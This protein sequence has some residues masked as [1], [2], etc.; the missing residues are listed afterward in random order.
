MKRME[1]EPCDQVVLDRDVSE[2][3]GDVGRQR[4]AKELVNDVG[5]PIVARVS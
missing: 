1:P 4:H 2:R 3:N 5:K